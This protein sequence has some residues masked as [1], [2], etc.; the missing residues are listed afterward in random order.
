MA[1]ARPG[2]V[3]VY[4]LASGTI[5][6]RL[7]PKTASGHGPFYPNTPTEF[8][9]D[10]RLLAVGT[11]IGNPAV[12]DAATG[13]LRYRLPHKDISQIA[14]SPDGT[15]VV[16]GANDGTAR[17][18]D[19]QDGSLL[20]VLAGHNGPVLGL[21]FSP[22]GRL[23]ATSSTDSTIKLWPVSNPKSNALT[24]SGHSAAVYHVQFSPDGRRL[25]SGSRDTTARV[26]A[27]NTDDLTA[28]AGKR[29]TRG[30][31]DTE[32]KQY[33]HVDTCP[34]SSKSAE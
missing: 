32:C 14:F 20:R 15:L 16:T 24:L 31:T 8:S 6:L 12:R 34:R 21:D 5:R 30:L 22:D 23:L 18:W 11:G 10:G 9:P 28:I 33:L 19:A 27:I 25:V 26:W 1:V 13:A 3:L 2:G 4:D 17:L 7:E 29:V